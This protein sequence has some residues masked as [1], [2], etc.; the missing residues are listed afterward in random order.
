[1]IHFLTKPLHS[2]QAV[3]LFATVAMAL[4][5]EKL[6]KLM[7]QFRQPKFA[8]QEISRQL[9]KRPNDPYILVTP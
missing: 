2:L 7:R 1:L 9:K 5:F 3:G 8:L 4:N 6:D